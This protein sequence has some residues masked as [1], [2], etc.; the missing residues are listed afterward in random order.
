MTPETVIRA[1]DGDHEAFAALA[2]GSIDRLYRVA[3][4]VLRDPAFAEDV[5]QDTLLEAW[6]SLP[7]LRDPD[8]FDAWLHRLLVRGCIRVGR[9]RRRDETGQVR[10]IEMDAPTTGDGQRGLALRDQVE[11]GLRR[12]APDQRVLL[13]LHFYL[14]LPEAEIAELVG[15][16]V[17]TV[18]SRLHRASQQM[19]AALEAEERRPLLPAGGI[20]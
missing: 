8:R 16:P 11:Q 9:R 5:V 19:R 2:A 18:K 3:R 7:G 4:M 1:R 10:L 17:G 20:D 6:R 14:D 12:L 15:I 13:V